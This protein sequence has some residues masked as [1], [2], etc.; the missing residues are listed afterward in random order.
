MNTDKDD[1][2]HWPVEVELFESENRLVVTWEDG[3]ISDFPLRY[4]RGFCPCAA[5]QG[6]RS[7]P[8]VFCETENERVDEV[9]QVGAY[10]MNV[11]WDSGHN[12]GIYSFSI[13]RKLCPC[14]EHL[15]QGMDEAW[16]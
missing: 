14:E 9:R 4:L 6:H 12:T 5:C 13:L 7:G 10:G 2:A 3:H 11:V 15:P 1:A 8:L 16:L